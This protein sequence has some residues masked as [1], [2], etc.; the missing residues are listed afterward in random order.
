MNLRVKKCRENIDDRHEGRGWGDA[1]CPYAS[2]WLTEE[3]KFCIT[4]CVYWNPV[5]INVHVTKRE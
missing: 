5:A 4:S 3:H 2:W 1:A